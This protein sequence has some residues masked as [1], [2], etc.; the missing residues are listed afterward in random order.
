MYIPN[1]SQSGFLDA[2]ALSIYGGSLPHNNLMSYLTLY[3]NIALQ[4]VFP[5]RP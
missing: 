3:F 2:T 4:G 1:G 5:A